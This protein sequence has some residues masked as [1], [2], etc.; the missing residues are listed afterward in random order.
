MWN[1]PNILTLLRIA[2]IPVFVVIFYLPVPWARL[3][4]AL[5]FTAAA[6]TDWLDGWLARRWDQTSPLGAFLDP[7]ADKLMVAIALVLLV[8]ADPRIVLALP[9]AVIIG[10][11]ITVSALREWMAEIGARAQVAVSMAGKLKTTAQMIAIVLL[12]LHEPVFGI[13]VLPIGLILLYVAAALTLWSMVLYMR[14]AWPSLT[15]DPNM[16]KTRPP[17]GHPGSDGGV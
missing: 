7:V 8:Q 2:L 1:I 10:R 12:I 15:A 16:H 5:V 14:A 4:C 11:E 17:I 13:P 9:A 3:V 6:I